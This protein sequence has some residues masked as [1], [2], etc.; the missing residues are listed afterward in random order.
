MKEGEVTVNQKWQLIGVVGDER[1]NTILLS[2]FVELGD[3]QDMPIQPFTKQA[4]DR[5]GKR[6]GE[7]FEA[8]VTHKWNKNGHILVSAILEDLKEKV[9]FT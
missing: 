7:T 9:V 1:T 5:W 2:F 6:I 4:Y 3:I 8:K